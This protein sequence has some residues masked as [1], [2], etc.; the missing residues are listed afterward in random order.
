MAKTLGT[1]YY[2]TPKALL[3]QISAWQP[4]SE[5][6]PVANP[7]RP[8]NVARPGITENVKNFKDNAVYDPGQHVGTPVA[9]SGPNPLLTEWGDESGLS[10]P[11]LY[12]R[13]LGI[14]QQRQATEYAKAQ[15]DEKQRAIDLSQRYGAATSELQRL[16]ALYAQDQEYFSNPKNPWRHAQVSAE[17]LA[18]AIAAAKQAEAEFTAH[19]TGTQGRLEALRKEQG[20]LYQGAEASVQDMFDVRDF[21]RDAD[22]SNLANKSAYEQKIKAFEEAAKGYQGYLG[23][24]AAYEQ[25]AAQREADLAAGKYDVDPYGFIERG[26]SLPEI[27][28]L[29]KQLNEGKKRPTMRVPV[30]PT[31]PKEVRDPGMRPEEAAYIEQATLKPIADDIGK[32]L[33]YKAPEPAKSPIKNAQK[34]DTKTPPPDPVVQATTPPPAA[35]VVEAKPVDAPKPVTPEPTKPIEEAKPVAQQPMTTQMT[36][37]Q[38]TQ[39][40]QQ[41]I[42]TPQPKV[43]PIN[44]ATSLAQQTEG[45]VSGQ[46]SSSTTKKEPAATPQNLVKPKPFTPADKLEEEDNLWEI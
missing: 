34:F 39:T 41:P 4:P 20:R 40:N 43:E 30:A 12:Q 6:G 16:Q 11:E 28:E 18:A 33:G 1:P 35:P 22:A 9:A 38:S 37:D 44:K 24:K 13:R 14:I 2:G 27:L 21:N 46:G 8:D 29:R 26:A 31:A 36:S 7:I 42:V 10:G 23:E 3:D 45:T 17:E 25:A 5:V 19:Q 15:E 32:L